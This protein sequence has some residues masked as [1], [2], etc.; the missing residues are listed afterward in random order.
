MPSFS[1]RNG[2]GPKREAL[3]L[4]D[5]DMALRNSLWNV[6]AV[7]GETFLSTLALLVAQDID[8]TPVHTVPMNAMAPVVKEYVYERFCASDWWKVLNILETSIRLSGSLC[9]FQ[10]DSPFTPDYLERAFNLVLAREASAW[11]VIRGEVVPFAD[12]LELSTIQSAKEAAGNVGLVV[13]RR[14]LEKATRFLA[15]RPTGDY[16]NA[17]AE[18]ILAVESACKVLADDENGTL[19][20]ALKKLEG[21]LT[22][23]PAFK[24][25][26]GNLYGYASDTV[27]HG[28][29]EPVVVDFATAKF[30]VVTCSAILNFLLD[31][32]RAQGLLEK[33]EI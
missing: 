16:S 2:Y 1:E 18:A 26:L 24:A 27:R 6:V 4:T 33:P 29:T 23:H 19:G 3:Q 14:H 17:I 28:Q 5:M 21:K 11:R 20:S 22:L 31:S 9:K 13:A 32:A 15:T 10:P 12:E 30:M 8:K 7:L 25:A